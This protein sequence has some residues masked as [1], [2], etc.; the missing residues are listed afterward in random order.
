MLHSELWAQVAAIVGSGAGVAIAGALV[1][2]AI[3]VGQV[4]QQVRDLPCRNNGVCTMKRV[5]WTPLER[6]QKVGHR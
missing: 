3:D 6:R 4:K 1:K 5:V 2:L